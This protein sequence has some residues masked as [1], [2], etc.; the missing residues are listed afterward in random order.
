M[1]LK[2]LMKKPPVPTKRAT[3]ILMKVKTRNVFIRTL[4]TREQAKGSANKSVKKDWSRS[5]NLSKLIGNCK[6]HNV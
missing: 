4:Y 5:F 6:Y 1:T 3:V 2:Y